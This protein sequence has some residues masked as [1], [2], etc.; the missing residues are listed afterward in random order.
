MSVSDDAP[1]S[2]QELETTLPTPF[3]FFWVRRFL[4]AASTTNG[5]DSLESMSRLASS[6]DGCT[7]SHC[8]R[9]CNKN[10]PNRGQIRAAAFSSSLTSGADEGEPTSCKSGAGNSFRSTFPFRLR[11]NDS[12]CVKHD[13][14]IKDG[15]EAAASAMRASLTE[16]TAREEL[17]C[18][19]SEKYATRK[20]S[21][22][23]S[24]VTLATITCSTA[25]CLQ[26]TLSISVTSIRCPRIFT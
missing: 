26:R 13:G 1:S 18:P 7:S 19:R 23:A 12:T 3:L 10:H 21:V 4:I 24:F 2:I 16:E 11:E 5:S 17:T 25:G 9:S 15:K 8:A 6:C 22:V 20:S 14:T